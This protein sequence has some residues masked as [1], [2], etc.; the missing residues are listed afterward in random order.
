MTRTC[1]R[2]EQTR[3]YSVIYFTKA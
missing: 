3:W 1:I 2:R